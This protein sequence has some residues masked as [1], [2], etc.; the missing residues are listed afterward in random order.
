MRG[1]R[2]FELACGYIK[3]LCEEMFT[4]IKVEVLES[5]QGLIDAD[6]QSVMNGLSEAKSKLIVLITLKTQFWMIIPWKLAGMF[7]WDSSKAQ[8]CA[9]DCLDQ[10]DRQPVD[11]EHHRLSVEFLSKTGKWR[12]EVEQLSLGVLFFTLPVPFIIRCMH[13]GLVPIVERLMEQRHAFANQRLRIGKRKKRGPTTVSLGAGRMQEIERQLACK[14]SFVNSLQENVN[15]FRN[16]RAA[17]TELGLSTHPRVASLCRLVDGSQQ[18]KHHTYL[19]PGLVDIVYRLDPEDQYRSTETVTR[20]NTKQMREVAKMQQKLTERTKPT[21]HA[22]YEGC[23]R[24]LMRQHLVAECH[25]KGPGYLFSLRCSNAVGSDFQT[26]LASLEDHLQSGIGQRVPMLPT[27]KRL[28]PRLALQQEVALE[29]AFA[30]DS[31]IVE[32][33]QG[34]AVPDGEEQASGIV[35]PVGDPALECNISE[36]HFKVIYTKGGRMRLPRMPLAS[37]R[38]LNHSDI[39]V[40]LH[41]MVSNCPGEVLLQ[42]APQ[43]V[44]GYTQSYMGLLSLNDVDIAHLKANTKEWTGT[45][46]KFVWSSVVATEEIVNV[47]SQLV[48][49]GAHVRQDGTTPCPLQVPKHPSHADLLAQVTSVA[50][51]FPQFVTCLEDTEVHQAWALTMEGTK[52]VEMLHGRTN[53]S[54]VFEL[55]VEAPAN[56][57][58]SSYHLVVFLE[59]RYGFQ[60]IGL[61]QKIVDRTALSFRPA[62]ISSPRFWSTGCR[63]IDPMY[64]RALA[65]AA[66]QSDDGI[67]EVKHGQKHSYY[68]SIL[69]L[70]APQQSRTRLALDDRDMDFP[71]KRHCDALEMEDAPVLDDG[72]VDPLLLE[73]EQEGLDKLDF[74]DF[75]AAL[76]AELQLED[77]EVQQD[78]LDDRDEGGNGVGTGN[79]DGQSNPAL[80]PSTLNFQWGVYRFTLKNRRRQNRIRGSAAAL[81]TRR[82]RQQDV[83]RHMW[84][85]RVGA[86]PGKLNPNKP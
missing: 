23:V 27:T 35:T 53:P 6:F 54:L 40:S 74:D 1:K 68:L 9:R 63:P 11:A 70:D 59:E 80:E 28:L 67:T 76:A 79:D 24:D 71:M 41:S 69:G 18:L 8:H 13:L 15:K 34:A 46:K 31:E 75:E 56:A 49:A 2:A 26:C 19:W 50:Q 52:Q 43:R 55:P 42:D 30:S 85:D 64:L 25:K 12:S 77:I 45:S 51:S 81:F 66:A 60:W 7:H 4:A 61:P 39:V 38:R 62:D 20:A 5:C 57:N 36:V 21:S 37:A 10:Y 14:P 84:C 29:E 17:V 44:A 83:A 72:N 32:S 47:V 73:D 3:E 33:E 22:S 82:I 58:M 16:A 48:Q 65:V 86:C 78:V